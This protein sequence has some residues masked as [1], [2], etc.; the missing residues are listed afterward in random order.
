M[1]KQFKPDYSDHYEQV[2]QNTSLRGGMAQT[3]RQLSRL[4]NTFQRKANAVA[5]RSV[6][7]DDQPAPERLPAAVG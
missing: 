1:M 2:S 6:V 4:H 3:S 7:E 5:A